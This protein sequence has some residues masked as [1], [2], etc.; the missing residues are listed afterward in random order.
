MQLDICI[1][2]ID[3][4]EYLSMRRSGVAAL[5]MVEYSPRTSEM[6]NKFF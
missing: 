6:I 4:S 5:P 1:R 3:F 2:L